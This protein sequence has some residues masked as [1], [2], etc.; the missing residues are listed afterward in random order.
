MAALW[1]VGIAW[2][3]CGEL[4]AVSGFCRASGSKTGRDAGEREEWKRN[5]RVSRAGYPYSSSL[6]GTECADFG[7]ADIS[8]YCC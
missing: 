3:L 7:M 6:S 8:F 2:R 4:K 5:C 1:L